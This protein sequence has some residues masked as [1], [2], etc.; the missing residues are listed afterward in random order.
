MEGEGERERGK[1]GKKEW[2]KREWIKEMFVMDNMKI[3]FCN[4]Y[5]FFFFNHVK[6]ICRKIIRDI[7]NG[8]CE[9]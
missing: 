2:K 4:K 9:D 6:L 5:R 3:I 8:G 7:R 1:I